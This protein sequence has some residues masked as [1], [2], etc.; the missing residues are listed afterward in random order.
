MVNILKINSK[1]G[2]SRV[3]CEIFSGYAERCIIVVG[4]QS[5]EDSDS[6]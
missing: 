2:T 6:C 4:L 3:V 5:R 1:E